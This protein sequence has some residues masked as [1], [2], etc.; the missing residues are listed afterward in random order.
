MNGMLQDLI[1][2]LAPG[3]IVAAGLYA[4]LP[5]LR[6]DAPAARIVLVTILL[7]LTW[8]YIGWRLFASL[9]PLAFTADFIV[10]AA[11]F[12]V[13][14][15]TVIGTTISFVFLARYRTRTPDVEA[16]TPWLDA[17]WPFP[18]LVDVLICT[19][20]EEQAILERTIDGALAMDYANCRIWV[21]DDG[22]RRWLEDLCQRTG[23]RY[24]TRPDNNHAKA[25]NI[26]HALEHIGRLDELPEFIAVLDADFVPKASF[27]ARTVCLMRDESVGIVQT[28]QHFINPDPIQ[29]NLA[30]ADVWPDEQR[31]FF[32]VLMPSKDAWGAAFCCGTSS[33]I[34]YSA[35][36]RI[37]G[38]PTDSVTEDYLLT[39]TLRTAGYQT[40]YLNEKLSLGLAPEGLK[41]YITQ[42][43]RWCLGLVQICRSPLGPLRRNKLRPID[44]ISLVEA[45]LYWSASYAFRLLCLVVPILYW[46]FGIQA[47]DADV[48]TT[49]WYFLPY[50]ACQ[51]GVTVW[52]S[53]GRMLPVLA[54]VSQL[55]TAVEILKS[56]TIGMARPKGH[57]FKVTA[58]GGVRDRRV[59]QWAILNRFLVLI[60][61]T[62]SGIALAFLRGG[63][64]SLHDA[65]ALCLF[66]SW[67]N[68]AVLTVAMTICIEQPR[69]QR[70]GRINVAEPATLMIGDRCF[71]CR[72][73][74]MSLSGLRVAGEAPAA[75]GTAL[76]VVLGNLRVPA[77][78]SRCGRGEFGL[79]FEDA[80]A[81]R[82]AVIRYLYSGVDRA[83]ALQVRGIDVAAAVVGRMFR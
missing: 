15:L 43:S 36:R 59:V 54:E 9:P 53:D 19:Y 16:N 2:L 34:R 5:W 28:P 35:L 44:R 6:R 66:W 81:A 71:D 42:R 82:D 22:R 39:L 63:D 14:C 46:L 1:E 38:V 47:I 52:L 18:P 45:F 4:I 30:A 21:L 72:I 32:D 74:D 49:L 23:A 62:I 13:E 65:G 31:Y 37:G 61:L 78:L 8:R 26:N 40:V 70:D 51:V 60:G 7:V 67:Y 24:L 27:L 11:F 50:F 73:V 41:E 55:L 33:L 56:A 17:Q 64:Q 20:N 12:A 77:V 75:S 10:G 76:T 79:S 57:R 83:R 69:Y 3:L 68:V 80:P 48:E 58:K 29:E 25:G